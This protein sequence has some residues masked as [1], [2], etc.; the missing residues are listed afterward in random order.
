MIIFIM[1]KRISKLFS[2]FFLLFFIIILLSPSYIGDGGAFIKLSSYD[3]WALLSEEKQMGIINYNDGKQDLMIVINIKDSELHH[4][5]SAA[6]LF[7]IPSNPENININ[8]LDEIPELGGKNIIDMAK[9][10]NSDSFSWMYFSQLHIMHFGL[11]SSIIFSSGNA[12]TTDLRYVAMPLGGS[13]GYD[14]RVTIHQHIE[15]MG[16]T[17]ELVSTID[18]DAFNKYLIDK[19]LNLTEDSLL[20]LDE[21]VGNEYSFVVTWISNITQF[22]IE[23]YKEHSYHYDDS[24]YSIGVWINFPT[25][26]LY[27]PMKLTSVYK[28]QK[29]PIL[30][31]ILNYITCDSDFIPY[32]DIEI[33]Y[34]Y[35]EECDVNSLNLTK[36]FKGFNKEKRYDLYGFFDSYLIKNIKYT[37]ITIETESNN[38]IDDLWFSNKA[39][40]VVQKY[41]SIITYHFLLGFII[42]II[43][44]CLASLLSGIITIKRKIDISYSKLFFLGLGNITSFVGFILIL[45]AFSINKNKKVDYNFLIPASIIGF[46]YILLFFFKGAIFGDLLISILVSFVFFGLGLAFFICFLVKDKKLRL[47]GLFFSIFFF[48]LVFIFQII[49]A[50]LI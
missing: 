49:L 36:F 11:I 7:P 22:L 3:E 26:K 12:H 4:G 44:S 41:D 29:I 35:D 46:F 2:F 24:F 31:Q 23:N 25:D 17:T 8:L 37:E 18:T 19:N 20:V 21:Y 50:R 9:D 28:E 30:L 45:N 27:Y 34:Y 14:E 5:E 40:E 43:C 6:W 1:T 39:P 15:E 13:G 47:Y 33:D 10:Y 32:E 38:F 16:L 48:L 42:F